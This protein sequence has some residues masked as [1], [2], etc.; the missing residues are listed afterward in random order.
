MSEVYLLLHYEA[1]LGRCASSV[2]IVAASE[3]AGQYWW[4]ASTTL[5]QTPGHDI[6]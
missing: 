6:P 2:Q 5:I 3:T 4:S 1:Q